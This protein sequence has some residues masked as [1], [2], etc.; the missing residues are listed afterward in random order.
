MTSAAM[1]QII[2]TVACR[3]AARAVSVCHQ[4][5]G[6]GWSDTNRASNTLRTA[7]SPAI[8][9]ASPKA[10]DCSVGATAGKFTQNSAL[11]GARG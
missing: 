11:P 4:R 9:A 7:V 8:I 3:V 10:S 1:A 5:G 2:G 6:S